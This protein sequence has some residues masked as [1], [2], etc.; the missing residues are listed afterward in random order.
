MMLSPPM[1]DIAITVQAIAVVYRFSS[2]GGNLHIAIDDF[3][4]GDDALNACERSI[5]ENTHEVSAEQLQAEKHC[6]ELLR[7][8]TEGD[9]DLALTQ[10]FEG[11]DSRM[12]NLTQKVYFLPNGNTA[13]L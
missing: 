5:A 13:G 6:L 4:L 1:A 2:V 11:D 12:S 7:R 10:Y 9:R 3:N 8:L